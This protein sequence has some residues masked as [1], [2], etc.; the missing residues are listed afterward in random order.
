MANFDPDGRADDDR[1]IETDNF[2]PGGPSDSPDQSNTNANEDPIVAELRALRAENAEIKAKQDKMQREQDRQREKIKHGIESRLE[3]AKAKVD[4]A[5]E[6]EGYDQA[7][8]E[9]KLD[10]VNT[11][12]LRS[13]STEETEAMQETRTQPGRIQT[14]QQQYEAFTDLLEKNGLSESDL[15]PQGL[16]PFIGMTEGSPEAQDFAIAYGAAI[17]KKRKAAKEAAIAQRRRSEADE[18]RE[19]LDQYGGLGGIEAGGEPTQTG[20]LV[21]NRE[22]QEKMKKLRGTGAVDVALSLRTEAEAKANRRR[23]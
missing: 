2:G 21:A 17:A 14:P 6:V 8:Y 18:T 1:E 11:E 16:R 22:Y 4:A 10:K 12:I 5:R 7:T 9:K 13:L 19:A 3:K 15:G 20:D 23:A